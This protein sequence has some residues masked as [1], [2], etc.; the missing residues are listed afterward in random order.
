MRSG[1][2]CRAALFASILALSLALA[3]P[4]AQASTE[5]CPSAHGGPAAVEWG[6]NG[7]EQLAAGFRSVHEGVPNQVLG[8]SN[9]RAVQAGFKFAVALLGNCTLESWGS[10]NKAQLGNGNHL[11]AQNRPGP[12]VNLEDVKEV[13]VANAHAAALRYDGSVWT[14][15]A[16]EFGERGN[17]EKGF[18]RTALSGEQNARPRDEPIPAPGL[19]HVVQLADGGV[20]D[21]VLLADGEVLAWGEDQNGD[22]GTEQTGTEEEQCYGETHSRTPVPCSTVPRRVKVEGHPLTGVERIAA[23]GESAYAVRNGGKE[24]LAWGENAKGQLGTGDSERHPTPKPVMFTPPSPVVEL[25]GGAHHVL[26]RLQNGQVYA[27]GADE[28]G[29]LGFPS[30]PEG[31][32]GCGQHACAVMP[33]LVPSLT[34]VV[35][36]AAGE[37]DTLALKEEEGGKRVAYSFG[38][39]G[40]Q[41]VLG[42][43]ESAPETTSTPTP[44]KGLPSVGGVSASSNIA[45]AYLR[46]GAP[47]APLLTAAGATEA[48]EVGWTAAAEAYRLRWRPLGTKPWSKLLEREA[49]CATESGCSY[50]QTVSGLGPQPYEVDLVDAKLSEGKAG[51]EKS[52]YISA[53][54]LPAPGAPLNTA[55]PAISGSPQQGQSVTASTGTWTNSPT[56]YAYQWL[57]CEGYGEGGAEEELGQECEPVEGA[58][59]SAYT[60][61]PADARHSL[62]VTVKASNAAG[63]SMAVSKPEVVLGAGEETL[64]LAPESVS[65]PTITG[66]AVQGRTLTEHHG[67]WEGEVAGYSYKWLRCKGHTAQGAGTSCGAISGAS[68]QSYTLTAEDVGMWIEVQETALNSGGWNVASS[69][70][71]EAIPPEVPLN[72]ALPGITGTI[73]QGQ[74]LSV[75]EGTWTNAAKTPAWQWLRCG[76]AGS[77]CT[78]I[79]GATKKTY[80]LEPEDVGHT[81]EASETVENAIGHSVPATSA[82]TTVVPVPPPAPESTTLPTITGPAQQGQVLSEH[83]G[84]WTNEPSSYTYAW[85]RCSPT[86]TECKAIAGAT[87][88]SYQLTAADVGHSI[89]AKETAVNAGGSTIANSPGSATVSGAVPVAVSPPELKGPAQQEQPLTATPGTW[90]NEPT[91][92]AY[93]WLRCGS[94]GAGCTAISAAAGAAYTPVTADVGYTIRVRVNAANATGEGASVTSEASVQVLPAAPLA[95]AA[96]AITGVAV[97]GQQLTAHP[98]SWTSGPTSHTLAWM[99]CEASACTDIEGAISP[100]YTLTPADVGYTIAVRETASNA[101]GWN[102]SDSEA[103]ATVTRI[104]VARPVVGDVSPNRTAAGSEAGVTI[105]GSSLS[106]ATK[107]MFGSQ[108]AVAFSVA[109]ATSITATAPQ[110]AAQGVDVTVTTP[111]GT[112]AVVAADRFFYTEAPEFGRCLAQKGSGAFSTAACATTGT[113]SNFEWEP[114]LSAAGF[115]LSGK[116]PSIETASRHTVSC[117][118]ASGQG[119]YTG[120]RE[121]SWQLT[122]G[123]CESASQKCTSAGAAAGEVRSASLSGSLVW[124]QRSTKHVAVLLAPERGTPALL[125]MQCGS[126]VVEVKGS[127]LLPVKSGSMVS[128]QTLKFAAASRGVQEPSEYETAS[129]QAVPAYLELGSPSAGFERAALKLP[130][131]QTDEEAVEINPVI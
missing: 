33:T 30:S 35:Q 104:V 81:L 40:L 105:T 101:G 44:I 9:V 111:G 23:G 66:V 72:T 22:L 125:Q 15:G 36:L 94:G 126:S 51:H 21:F 53:T 97:E 128:S 42:L 8:L 49:T 82:A 107:V 1:G 69:E 11:Q 17:G 7:S 2:C 10:N 123:G 37:A 71:V 106:G 16:S 4:A 98:A 65:A 26:A 27:W 38:R 64:S 116:A 5:G 90:A 19:E 108:P 73:Q 109:S 127:V 45:V 59:A 20:R 89:V 12:V 120:P 41:E 102:A 47:P 3:C 56:S 43:G 130:L 6:I 70:A 55:P 68:A 80:K 32:E 99:R 84:A 118:S 75:R 110:N 114:Q 52:R 77:G 92:Y 18:E 124:E 79:S 93:Q 50:Q 129:G 31:S 62:R 113:K 87:K 91:S 60:P 83:A 119:S 103:T 63:W 67:G 88:Q 78:A 29:Q 85:K 121:S 117:T 48:L 74:T 54:P 24:V 100:T 95:S 61:Q 58:T 57:R 76:V 112:S 46:E 13:S 28:S 14:W 86:G 25:D 34:H 115:S 96:P 131:T 122:F 39:N